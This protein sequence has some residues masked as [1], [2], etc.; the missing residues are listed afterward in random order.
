MVRMDNKTP[1]FGT[2][3]DLSG[4]GWRGVWW[5]RRKSNHLIQNLVGIII[6]YTAIALIIVNKVL[7]LF[8]SIEVVTVTPRTKREVFMPPGFDDKSSIKTRVF[9][10][11][12]SLLGNQTALPCTAC[13]NLFYSADLSAYQS[14]DRSAATP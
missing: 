5:R 12:D 14:I 10:Q 9:H 11:L 4:L 3:M 1:Y 7:S 8:V 6:V 13:S 2:H